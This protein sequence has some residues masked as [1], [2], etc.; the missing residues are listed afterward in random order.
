[1]KTEVEFFEG[2]MTASGDADSDSGF[3][4]F[5]HAPK[6]LLDR[7]ETL[8]EKDPKTRVRVTLEVLQPEM[9]PSSFSVSSG[10]IS[11]EGL[12]GLWGGQPAFTGWSHTVLLPGVP[13]G[14]FG[15]LPGVPHEGFGTEDYKVRVR[16]AEEVVSAA[17]KLFK[18]NLKSG[19]VLL[20]VEIDGVFP[21]FLVLED[22]DHSRA[23]L[24]LYLTKVPRRQEAVKVT[25]FWKIAETP[26]PSPQGC[27]R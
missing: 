16:A 1:M 15:T 25:A 24:E 12:E 19:V 17:S 23:I 7:L 18:L 3:G 20:S 9:K 2:T 13:H 11:P 5:F 6:G 8:H 27:G 22:S 21:R 4:V 14:G 10:V 26:E